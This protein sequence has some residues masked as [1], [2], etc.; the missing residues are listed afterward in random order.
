MVGFITS[1]GSLY[2]RVIEKVSRHQDKRNII[3][4]SRRKPESDEPNRRDFF[5]ADKNVRHYFFPDFVYACV[6]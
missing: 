2:G 1:K 6:D 4:L 3:L 5:F